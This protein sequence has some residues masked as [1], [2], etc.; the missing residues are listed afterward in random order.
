LKT[1]NLSTITAA[2]LRRRALSLPTIIA[3]AVGAALLVLTLLAVFDEDWGQL[4]ENVKAIKPVPYA[5]AFVV[6]YASFWFRGLRWK[7]ISHQAGL[8]RFGGTRIP[9]TCTTAAIILMGWFANSVAFLRAGDAYRAWSMSR[10]TGAGFPA[11]LG[12]VLAERV[13]DMVAV[14]LL[15][16]V[17]AVWVAV[18]TRIEVPAAV[19]VAAALLVA[20]LLA[21]VAAM[22]VYGSRVSQRLPRRLRRAYLRFQRGTLRSFRTRQLPLQLAL[23]L[24]GWLLEIG[25]FYF[26]TQGL[27]IEVSFGVVMFA[28]LAN[29]MLTTI[30]TPGGFGFVEVGLTGLLVL[31]GLDDTAALSLTLVDRTISWVS[32]VVIGGVSLVSWELYKARQSRLKAAEEAEAQPQSTVTPSRPRPRKDTSPT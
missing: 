15:V 23:G 26:V 18:D 20:A 3:V 10:E 25:R 11:S 21:G 29:A 2:T 14:L 27:G 6:Y 7:L 9:G 12:T 5:L 17:A 19:I 30:P 28:A 22:Q 8:D 4:W 31:L 1:D 13:Q 32:V 16:L 24:I